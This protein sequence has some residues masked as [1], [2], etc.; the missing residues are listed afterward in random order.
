MPAALTWTFAALGAAYWLV[1]VFVGIAMRVRL[2][3]LDPPGE[4]LPAAARP[5]VS[6]VVAARDEVD[7]IAA[8]IETARALEGVGWE[9]VLVDDRSTD[10]TGALMD[11]AAASDARIRVVHVDELPA[12]WLGKVH[13]LERG[14]ALARGRWLLFTDADVELAPGSLA[15]A[16]AHVESLRLD[17]LAV[18]PEIESRGLWVAGAV[19]T[20]G[21]WLVLGGGLWR[22]TD[23][24]SSH[25]FGIGAFNLVRADALERA[26]GFEW[27]RMDVADDA[28]LA[29]LI[30]QRG[31]RT[32]LASGRGL[33]RVHWQPSVRAMT[34]GFEK[35]GSSG[36]FGSHGRAVATATF[37]ALS[38]LAPAIALLLAYAFAPGHGSSAVSIVVLLT[39][40]AALG[41][42]ALLVRS[43]TVPARSLVTL[44]LAAAL[45]WFMLVRASWLEHRRGGLVWRDTFYATADIRA[46]RR[47][48]L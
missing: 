37:A 26:G 32:Q 23:A 42:G 40:V 13:A 16:I 9:L 17:Q 19:G 45:V 5:D 22:A 10:G 7:T 33:A 47:F 27:L 24:D 3:R 20:F 30:A 1:V 21:R 14:R 38:E 15:Q 25:A 2:T 44:P 34:R 48:S 12:G 8:S 41:S 18:L 43:G 35:Y 11:A 6:I 29:H 4:P 28:A 36:S 31:G 39:Y 46:G